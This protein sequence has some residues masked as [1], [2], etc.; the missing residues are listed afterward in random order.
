MSRLYQRFPYIPIAFLTF[1]TQPLPRTFLDEIVSRHSARCRYRSARIPGRF[2]KNQDEP[3]KV[4]VYFY[5]REQ[6][7]WRR[8][9][10]ILAGKNQVEASPCVK[11]VLINRSSTSHAGIT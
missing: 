6:R 1:S 7:K 11:G 4:T 9:L 5:M 10:M 2:T 8:T 3:K